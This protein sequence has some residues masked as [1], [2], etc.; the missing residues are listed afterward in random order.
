MN[1]QTVSNH[2]LP[3]RSSNEI[4]YVVWWYQR[5]VTGTIWRCWLTAFMSLRLSADENHIYRIKQTSEIYDWILYGILL[6]CTVSKTTWNGP[7]Q[8]AGQSL[9]QVER[10]WLMY[11][12]DVPTR[13]GDIEWLMH[14]CFKYCVIGEK[15]DCEHV[16]WPNIAGTKWRC[17]Q[18]CLIIK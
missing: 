7:I 10:S 16:L 1:R 14:H 11:T 17:K 9:I 15:H 2:R 12:D 6:S 8:L 13:R 3:Y 5:Q 18:K 4:P